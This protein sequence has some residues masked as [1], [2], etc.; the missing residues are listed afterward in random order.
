MKRCK[1]SS[2]RMTTAMIAVSVLSLAGSVF[3]QTVDQVLQADLRRLQLAQQAQEQ[4]NEV[5]ERTRSL[6]DQYRSIL[7]ENEGLEVY[8]R[9]MSAQ[10]EGQRAVLAD[11]AYSMDQVDVINRQ[12]FPLMERMIDGLEQSVALDVPFLLEERNQ[13]IDT[14]KA[15]MGRSDVS[16]A[17][18]F[19]KVMEAYQIEMD[20][21]SS[22]EWYRQTLEIEGTNR[23]YNMLRIGRTGLYFQSDDA[24]ITGMYDPV[25]REYTLLDDEHRSE[26]RK[27]L[28]MARQLIAPELIL[29]PVESAEPFGEAS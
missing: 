21:G 17:E 27:G 26:I 6:E 11:I 29:I 2:R 9:L 7:K 24:R 5:V 16:V 28:R 8:N 18:K 4:V 14:L 10:V 22:S 1:S 19:R 23:D 25:S 12:I 20:Y 13:R 15:L 3:A